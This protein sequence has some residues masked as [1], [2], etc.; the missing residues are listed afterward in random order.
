M[1][2]F[3]IVLSSITAVLVL[4]SVIIPEIGKITLLNEL[5]GIM[6][7]GSVIVMLVKALIAT[8]RSRK[9]LNILV[10]SAVVLVIGIVAGFK[11][12]NVIKDVT[13]G[14]EW[15]TISNCEVEK[16]NTSRGIFGLNYYLKGEDL[17]GDVYR[18]SISGKEF[19]IL[20]GEDEVSVLCYK[21]TERIVEVKR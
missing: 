8:V 19:D 21:N 11:S 6:V 5:L 1:P 16:R 3:Y 2:V 10:L 13:S 14:P 4:C 7:M 15:I 12:V 20:N 17:N 18:F 9:T